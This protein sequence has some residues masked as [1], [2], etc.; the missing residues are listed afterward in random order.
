VRGW[1]LL[2]IGGLVGQKRILGLKHCLLL[3]RR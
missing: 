3:A 2:E 1:G